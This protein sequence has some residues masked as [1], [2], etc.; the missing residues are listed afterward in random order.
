MI[1]VTRLNGVFLI[2]LKSY[3]RRCGENQHR[4]RLWRRKYGSS[5]QVRGTSRGA[6]LVLPK[7]GLIPAGAGK[8][9]RICDQAKRSAAHPRRCGE[10]FIPV[11]Q[12]VLPAGSSP[13][14]RGKLSALVLEHLENRLIPAGAGKTRSITQ[15]Q[16]YVPAHPRRCGENP[17]DPDAVPT[18]NG[19]SPQVRGKHH[20]Y[21][22]ERGRTR[23][24]P[25]G[26]GKTG[27][28]A[29]CFKLDAAHPRG[30]GENFEAWFAIFSYS[31]SSPQVRGKRVYTTQT[32][33]LSR[34]IPA[35]AGKTSP[36][37]EAYRKVPAHPR[38]CG[39]N[40]A[41]TVILIFVFGSSPQVR[42][43]PSW[44]RLY[45]LDGRL[46]PAGAGKTY[47]QR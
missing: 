27:C 31:G 19:S 39:E 37:Q 17:A 25:A 45:Y 8:T 5:P 10:N 43:K 24:I 20:A 21:T 47:S 6:A 11:S 38:R 7:R 16:R 33:T 3:P 42:G 29:G 23:L 4:V 12:S 40:F 9:C 13:Q 2:G 28:D 44:I 46:I 34:L 18:L 35:G 22:L 1:C 30:C 26:A 36:P 15:P 32:L 14:V 41:G